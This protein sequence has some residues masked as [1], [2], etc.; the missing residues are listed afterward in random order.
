MITSTQM[1]K[2]EELK[3]EL[4]R[5]RCILIKSY[6][7]QVHACNVVI[8]NS[9]ELG[10]CD[11]YPHL[12]RLLEWWERR[13]LSILMSVKY[14]KVVKYVGYWR[15]NDIVPVISYDI[16]TNNPNVG[17]NAYVIGDLH[18]KSGHDHPPTHVI[19][20][21]KTEYEHWKRVGR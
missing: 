15:V 8:T 21:T 19:P 10:Y 5:P 3:E 13:D 14:V 4:L 18:T 11:T 20:A 1:S 9:T 2:D 7:N 16:N 17:F 6:P 12:Y